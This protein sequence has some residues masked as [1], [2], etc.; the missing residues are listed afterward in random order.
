MKN[1]LVTGASGFIGRHL[2]DVLNKEGIDTY[3]VLRNENS[4]NE[5][6]RKMS[7]IV[8]IF[9]DLNDIDSLSGCLKNISIDTCIHLAWAGVSGKDRGDYNRQLKNIENTLK[10]I[11]VVKQ[12]GCKR[13]VGVGSTAEY[14]SYNSSIEDGMCPNLV[15]MYGIAKLSTHFMTKMLCNEYGV[16]HIW[17]IIGNTYGVGDKSNNFVNFA[18]KL[19]MSEKEAKFTS[20]EQNYDFVY[21]TDV[22]KALFCLGNNGKNKC[23]YYIG[24]GE[25]RKLK[26]Y[27]FSIR[28]A[29]NPNKELK[30]GAITFNGKSADIESYNIDKLKED[31]GFIPEVP[32]EIGIIET[33]KWLREF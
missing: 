33:V 4:Y 31:T 22:A 11:T 29:I 30:L 9:C 24:S 20:G 1:V 12:F 5:D 16:E 3:V 14:D 10:L 13:F 7:N 28:D 25:P 6:L 2:C 23:S 15:S 19:I 17:G 18:S 27:I 26:E 32:F 21:I 8:P